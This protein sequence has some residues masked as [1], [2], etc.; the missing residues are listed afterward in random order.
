MYSE[1][2]DKSFRWGMSW[3]IFSEVMFFAAFFGALFYVRT[4]AVPWLGG[5]GEKG[6]TNMLWQG[7][8]AQWPLMTTP[9]MEGVSGPKEIIDPWHIP[10]LNTVLLLSSSVTVTL[11]HHALRKNKRDAIVIWLA[12]TILLGSV[13]IYFQAEEYR[14]LSGAGAHPECGYLWGDLLYPDR[15]PWSA[16]NPGDLHVA[17]DLGCA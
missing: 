1:Q 9:D 3:F 8:E 16:C 15:I 2:M 5:E 6:I 17:G 13:F 4:L 10:L 11:A 14:C 7:F 12:A